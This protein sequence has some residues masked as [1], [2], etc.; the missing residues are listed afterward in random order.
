ME[1]PLHLFRFCPRCGSNAFTEN[2]F[3]SKRCHSC[4]FVY[5]FNP[6]AATAAIITDGN[7]NILVARRSKEPAKGTFDL[8]GGFCDS[9]ETAEECVAREVLEETGLRIEDAEYL[10]SI[11]NR[12]LYSGMEL[13]T[14]DMF[15]LCTVKEN[16]V[17]LPG[18]DVDSLQW[19]PIDRLDSDGFGLESI[20]KCIERFKKM[21]IT[22]YNK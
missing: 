4:G 9:F 5:Y 22:T 15:F 20:R 11:P 10:F 7:G 18:D 3:K 16:C 14:M 2:D 21:Y 12:Y 17:V 6:L 8:P 13:H 19:L 1:H